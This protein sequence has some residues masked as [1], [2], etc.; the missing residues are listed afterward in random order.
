MW[1]LNIY[2]NLYGSPEELSNA[3]NEINNHI[4]Q[5]IRVIKCQNYEIDWNY[6]QKQH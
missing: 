4:D 6:D 2:Y 1:L 5:H 3:K